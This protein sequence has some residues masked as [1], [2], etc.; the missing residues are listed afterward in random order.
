[1]SA[2]V[3]KGIVPDTQEEIDAYH[4]REAIREIIDKNW[5]YDIDYYFR[6]R[7][8]T[9]SVEPYLTP[10][11]IEVIERYRAAWADLESMYLN[12]VIENGRE[13]K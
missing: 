11:E 9:E 7:R 8:L 12:M 13:I 4:R 3:R 6:S 5:D 10:E 1:M 2:E